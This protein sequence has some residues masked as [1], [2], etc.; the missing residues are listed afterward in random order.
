MGVSVSVDTTSNTY[1]SHGRPFRIR[2][3][4][5]QTTGTAS[6]PT[7]LALTVQPANTAR[8]VEATPAVII[9]PSRLWAAVV[10]YFP[11]AGG[12]VEPFEQYIADVFEAETFA[13]CEL[14]NGVRQDDLSSLAEIGDAARLDD[15][16]S[17]EVVVFLNRFARSHSDSHAKRTRLHTLLQFEGESQRML[18]GFERDQGAVSGVLDET[19]VMSSSKLRCGCFDS[20]KRRP[21]FVISKTIENLR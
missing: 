20:P 11:D 5:W 18:G 7:E 3:E 21:T 13:Y 4:G 17:V 1:D 19:S 15:D 14:A 2:P 12:L 8:P 9:T 10:G 6:D 16:R